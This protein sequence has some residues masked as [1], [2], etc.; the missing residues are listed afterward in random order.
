MEDD[1]WSDTWKMHGKAWFKAQ[2]T[3]A[4]KRRPH[5]DELQAAERFVLSFFHTVLLHI[6]ILNDW[7]FWNR[8]NGKSNLAHKFRIRE[9]IPIV[10]ENNIK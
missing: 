5:H 3:P 7:Y 8:R 4:F 1:P 2:A 9:L 10:T 6:E